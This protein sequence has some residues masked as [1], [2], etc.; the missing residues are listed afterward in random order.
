V[1]D[2]TRQEDERQGETQAA[3]ALGRRR[4]IDLI[5]RV[6]EEQD[7][8]DDP[9]QREQV[10]YGTRHLSRLVVVVSI[11]RVVMRV[12]DPLAEVS[13]LASV[14]P[15]TEASLFAGGTGDIL[16]LDVLIVFQ[17]IDGIDAAARTLL[18]GTAGLVL[19]LG[20]LLAP[21]AFGRCRRTEVGAAVASTGTGRSA[22]PGSGTEASG[23]GRPR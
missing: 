15:F 18:D 10:G 8:E 21:Q 20:A 6:D 12:G 23:A 9:C 5:E 11:G 16:E 3:G 17:V 4:Q 2:G 1:P 7:T 14:S 19:L 13:I 22:G